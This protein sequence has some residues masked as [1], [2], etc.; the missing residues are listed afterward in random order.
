MSKKTSP[1]SSEIP[2]SACNELGE[3]IRAFLVEDG[4]KEFGD[5]VP[6]APPVGMTR[7]LTTEERF[8]RII[9]S[10]HMARLAEAAGV[11]TFEEAEDFDVDDDPQPPLTPYEEALLEPPVRLPEPVAKANAAGGGKGS[12]S[13]KKPAPPAPDEDAEPPS[14]PT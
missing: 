4:R 5:P 2:L 14:T 9:R 13:P 6:I 11:D 8:R 10:E 3:Q 12:G 1:A 7:P